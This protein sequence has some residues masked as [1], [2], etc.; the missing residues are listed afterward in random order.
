[1]Q[2]TIQ[3]VCCNGL[4]IGETKIETKER[5]GQRL[6]LNLIPEHIQEAME[7]VD[8]DHSKMKGWQREIVAIDDIAAWADDCV[9]EEWG[10]KAAARVF[11]ICD[12]RRDIEFADPF[13]TGAA[14]EKP[15]RYLDRAPGSPERTLKQYRGRPCGVWFRSSGLISWLFSG[16]VEADEGGTARGLPIGPASK[17]QVTARGPGSLRAQCDGVRH[18]RCRAGKCRHAGSSCSRPRAR[19][20][21]LRRHGDALLRRGARD[22]GR[23][24]NSTPSRR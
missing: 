4:V 21:A 15:I 6:S 11:H 14:T 1:M 9:S 24:R 19:P 2:P 5:H 22:D 8:A 18:A 12:S 17:Q 13:E 3:H 23:A 10:Q 7:A 20:R 16:E